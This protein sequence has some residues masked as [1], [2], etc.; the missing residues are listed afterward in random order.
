MNEIERAIKQML[1]QRGFR[2]LRNG[3]PDFLC[4]KD[5][6]GPVRN[7]TGWDGQPTAQVEKIKGICAVEVKSVKDKLTEGPRRKNIDKGQVLW[8]PPQHG[9]Q[10]HI[11]CGPRCARY[12]GGE[13]NGLF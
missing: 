7:F 11:A 9:P 1:E 2:A 3:W 5:T 10:P 8:S 4:I 12:V 13:V 6:L